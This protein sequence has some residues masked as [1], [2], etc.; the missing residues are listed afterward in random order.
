M[1]HTNIRGI[2]SLC[3]CSV[4]HPP[5]HNFQ[6]SHNENLKIHGL[7]TIDDLENFEF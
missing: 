1:Q 3:T 4:L 7:Y 2:A 5:V 6:L